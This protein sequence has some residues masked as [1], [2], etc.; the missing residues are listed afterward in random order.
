MPNPMVNRVAD[1]LAPFIKEKLEE[2]KSNYKWPLPKIKCEFCC[3]ELNEILRFAK[4]SGDKDADQLIAFRHKF[5]EIWNRGLSQEIKVTLARY[6]IAEWGGIRSNNMK[7]LESYVLNIDDDISQLIKQSKGIASKSKL[8]ATVCPQKFFVYDSWIAWGLNQFISNNFQNSDVC[9][10]F[11]SGRM[12]K[13]DEHELKTKLKGKRRLSYT[14]YCELIQAISS[15]ISGSED[16]QLIE[17]TLFYLSR[18]QDKNLL[19]S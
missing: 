12:P 7:T 9:F 10:S 19:I 6:V 18:S 17:M 16:S 1:K 3:S 11:I 14:D 8:L 2:C 13:P 15:K 5:A 4:S